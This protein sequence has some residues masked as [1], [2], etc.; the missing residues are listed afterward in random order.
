M[1]GRRSAALLLPA[2]CDATPASSRYLAT[3]PAPWR[4]SRPAPEAAKKK[5]LLMRCPLRPHPALQVYDF[6]NW[7]KHRS[8]FRLIDRLLQTPQ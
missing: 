5:L 7:Q 8:Q 4:A 2:R 1:S 6:P 3:S